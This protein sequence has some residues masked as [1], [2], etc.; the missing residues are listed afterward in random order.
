MFEIEYRVGTL[1]CTQ[2]IEKLNEKELDQ[3]L[4]W[5]ECAKQN[6]R[7]VRITRL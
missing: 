1:Y 2:L 4:L 7:L 3:F 6:M 5:A